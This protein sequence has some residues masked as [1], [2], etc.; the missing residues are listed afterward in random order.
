MSNERI[1]RL[2]QEVNRHTNEE[3]GTVDEVVEA[4]LEERV[5]SLSESE[6][7]IEEKQAELKEKFGVGSDDGEAAELSEAEKKQEEL[8]E[9]FSP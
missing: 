8:K 7:A 6:E 3:Y 9:R 1:V 4:V 5:D 2:A